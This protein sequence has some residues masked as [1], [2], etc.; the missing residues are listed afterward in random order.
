ML[1]WMPRGLAV[2]EGG[3]LHSGVVCYAARLDPLPVLLRCLRCL[4]EKLG[5]VVQAAAV[6]RATATAPWTY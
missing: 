2:W 5:T 3:T 6:P 4:G 1:A